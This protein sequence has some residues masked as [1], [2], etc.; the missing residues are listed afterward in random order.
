MMWNWTQ[1][2][3]PAFKYDA[4]QL[5]PLE[6]QFLLSSGEV[7]RAPIAVSVGKAELPETELDGRPRRTGPLPLFGIEFR[8]PGA[9]SCFPL[10]SPKPL[11]LRHFRH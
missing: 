4:A 10:P 1:Q 9:G 2:G 11:L 3:W 8:A 7:L 5:A 6:R